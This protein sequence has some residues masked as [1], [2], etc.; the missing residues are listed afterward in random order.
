MSTENV[1]K[2]AKER[3]LQAEAALAEYFR[4]N[5]YCQE[6]EEQLAEAARIARVEYVD[7]LSKQWQAEIEALNVP[8]FQPTP[9]QE[10]ALGNPSLS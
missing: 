9:S 5:A 3:M 10:T 6:Q 1:S 7:Q 8:D 4:R 2:R